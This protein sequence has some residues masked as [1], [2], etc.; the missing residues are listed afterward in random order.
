MA[1]SAGV[2]ESRRSDW[3]RK[4][5][6]LLSVGVGL[7]IALVVLPSSLN[8][9][10]ANPTETVE[11][12]PV[13]PEDEDRPPP[14]EG[15][16]SALG[17]GVS[18]GIGAGE[19]EGVGEGAPP[20]TVP[21]AGEDLTIIERQIAGQSPKAPRRKPPVPL[22][23]GVECESGAD[24]VPRQTFDPLSPPCV[25]F[26][27]GDNGCDTYGIGVTCDEIRF[28]V[29]LDGGINYV[30]GSNS[31]NRVAPEN[32]LYDLFQSPEENQRRNNPTNPTQ[33][34]HLTVQGLRVWQEYFNKRF[35]TYRRKVHFYV[36]F[37]G[38]ADRN[39]EGRRRNAAYI[40]DQVKPFAVISFA[41]EGSEDDFIT[42]LARK[43]VL[44]FGSFALRSQAELFDKFPKMIWSYYP[45]VEQQ[46]NNYIDYVCRKVVNQYP[47]LAG[48]DLQRRAE[49]ENGGRRRLGLIYADDRRDWPG[50][51]LM[52]QMV[53]QRVANCGGTIEAEATFPNCCL[54]QDNGEAPNYA[55]EAMAEFKRMGITTILWPGGINGNFGKTAAGLEYFPEWIIAGDTLLDANGPVILSQN[56][57]A[58]DGRAIVISPEVLHPALEQQRC[59]IA[60]RQI[61][62]SFPRSDLGYVCE[63]YPNLFQF[64]AGVQVAGPYLNPSSI[65]RGFHA[66]PQRQQSTDP[67]VPACFYE[68][69]DYTCVKDAQ[70]EI[71]DKD[72]RPPGQTTGTPGCWRAIEG[73]QRYLTQGEKPRP[74]PPGNIDAQITGNEPCNGYSSAVRFNLA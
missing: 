33:P 71:W 35:Q 37:S 34:E 70:A 39:P 12:A 48:P 11:F 55:V 26:F 60:F 4:Y 10:Q 43:G 2:S 58:F 31:G 21:P 8:L 53:K 16:L 52:A 32:K 5:P 74:W 7:L 13:P 22:Q 23:P 14:Q 19:G 67:T 73:G 72:G 3:A 50:L 64:F 25:P 1:A 47:S 44:N 24:G 69:G 30:S 15:N 28:V 59:Y 9:P 57:A 45:S 29:Y 42:A 54:A 18:A 56:S 68:P 40:Y 61:A 27:E 66:I 65:D 46:A 17:L 41:T 36:Y 49:L 20:T 6:P 62:P 51:Y 38:S 63:Y